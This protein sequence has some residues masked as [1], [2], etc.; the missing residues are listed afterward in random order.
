MPSTLFSPFAFVAGLLAVFTVL[1]TIFSSEP[2]V[3][4]RH[5]SGVLLFLLL[6]L[7]MDV[8][9]RVERARLLVLT[10]AASGTVLAVLGIWQFLHGGDDLG[11]RIRGTLSHYMTFSGLAMIA[12]LPPA[13]LRPRGAGPAGGWSA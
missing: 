3:S 8:V 10:L 12:A 11:N 7:T 5:V 2:A 6:P 13:R 9:D 4:A 1:S